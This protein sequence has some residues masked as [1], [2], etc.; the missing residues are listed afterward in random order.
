MDQDLIGERREDLYFL[1][2]AKK[3]DMTNI[4]YMRFRII[5]K[6][7]LDAA[8]EKGIQIIKSIE[9]IAQEVV[10]ENKE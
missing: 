6:S 4:Q 7:V 1:S 8:K 5:A 9:E 10:N 3:Y 2:I